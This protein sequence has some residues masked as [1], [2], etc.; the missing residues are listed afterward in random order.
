MLAISVFR[1]CPVQVYTVSS[2]TFPKAMLVLCRQ[3]DPGAVNSCPAAVTCHCT[4]HT[5]RAALCCTASSPSLSCSSSESPLGEHTGK[6]LVYNKASLTGARCLNECMDWL[7]V[8][9]VKLFQIYGLICPEWDR[10][11]RMFRALRISPL[12]RVMRAFIPS[13]L[14]STLK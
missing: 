3:E 13:S 7:S 12:D 6:K 5:G 2:V 1:G 9:L 4:F 11:C 8:G 10:T 14:I